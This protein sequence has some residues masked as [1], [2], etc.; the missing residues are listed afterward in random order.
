M[1]NRV[2]IEVQGGKYTIA[3][4]ESEAY[5]QELAR[6]L[7]EQVDLLINQDARLSLSDCLV[8]CCM[9]YLDGYK[10]SEVSSDHMRNQLSDYVEDAARA[11]IE[12]DEAKREIEYLKH[13]LDINNTAY[14]DLMDSAYNNDK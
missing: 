9:Q 5:V 8:L 12:L 4:P 6:E 13:Q 7:D 10:K 1:I 14:N 2:R 3:T 11:R